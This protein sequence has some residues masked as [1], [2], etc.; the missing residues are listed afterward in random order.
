MCF[1]GLFGTF[2]CHTL[3][4]LQCAYTASISVLK[5]CQ[6]S[7]AEHQGPFASLFCIWFNCIT[8][9]MLVHYRI[10]VDILQRFKEKCEA[11]SEKPL[12]PIRKMEVNQLGKRNPQ[13]SRDQNRKNQR[14]KSECWYIPAA[15]I[16]CTQLISDRLISVTQTKLFQFHILVISPCRQFFMW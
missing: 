1:G 15:I 14:R 16:T 10:C 7:Q 4:M 11:Q 8:W 3:H 2:V 13:Q 5:F 9:C 12:Q 6:C